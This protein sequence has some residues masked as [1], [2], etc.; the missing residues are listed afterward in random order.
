[1]TS[2]AFHP[3]S[4]SPPTRP[5]RPCRASPPRWPPRPRRPDMTGPT[6]PK[7][8]FL[9]LTDLSREELLELIERAAE[10]KLLGKGGPRPLSGMTL[11][12]VFEKAST[13]TRVSVQVGAHQV[14]LP[15]RLLPA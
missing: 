12:L 4:P 11:G 13:R 1:M 10:W 7:R 2:S 3:P 5:T 15:L 6:H 8:D 14:R 9:R